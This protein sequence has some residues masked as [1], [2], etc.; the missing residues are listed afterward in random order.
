MMQTNTVTPITPQTPLPTMAEWCAKNLRV[1]ST[2][3]SEYVV[4]EIM[5]PVPP[6]LSGHLLEIPEDMRPL[7][8]GKCVNLS[9]PCFAMDLGYGVLSE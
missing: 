1:I 5:A 3:A 9:Y 8:D 4:L 2:P 7:L 6:H